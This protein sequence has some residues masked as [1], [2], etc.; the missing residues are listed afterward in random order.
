[1]G[2]DDFVMIGMNADPE[3]AEELKPRLL[4]AKINWRQGLMGEEHP[5][6][7]DY[8]IPGYPTKIVID[9]NG[10]VKFI[11]HFVDEDQLKEFLKN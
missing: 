3:S 6:M 8:E 7:D 4:E 5:L 2:G 1:M 9:P 10:V 11:D